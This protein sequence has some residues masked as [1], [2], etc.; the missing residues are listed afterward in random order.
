MSTDDGG[1]G[2]G[3]QAPAFARIS[4]HGTSPGWLDRNTFVMKQ[5]DELIVELAK[6]TENDAALVPAG[7][8]TW[9]ELPAET[10]SSKELY[11]L[12]AGWMVNKKIIEGGRNGGENYSHKVCIQNVRI[13]IHTVRR[14][15]GKYSDASR[16]FFAC[17]DQGSRTPSSRWLYIL[18]QNITR[19]V[20][21]RDG[22]LKDQS[23]EPVTIFDLVSMNRAYIQV[24]DTEALMRRFALA[25]AWYTGGRSSEL[26]TITWDELRWDSFLMKVFGN[27]MQ[28]KVRVCDYSFCTLLLSILHSYCILHTVHTVLILILQSHLYCMY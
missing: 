10:M 18:C 2:G 12:H 8:K 20:S 16:D 25:S 23:A 11:E 1:G 28:D 6:S 24:G 21:K 14:A 13:V 3:P 4:G 7:C 27:S 26:G 17:V 9:K 15:H 19:N 5:F 22:G